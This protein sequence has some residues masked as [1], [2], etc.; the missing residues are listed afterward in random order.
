MS[1]Y[2]KGKRFMYEHVTHHKTI[3]IAKGSDIII[4]ESINVPRRSMRGLVLLFYGPYTAGT[5]NS[6]KSLNPN[7]DE[8]K[9]VVNGIPN[10]LFS[11]GIKTRDLWEE[12][13]GRFGKEK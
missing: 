4:N 6:E 5:R 11:Q 2:L 13:F 8:V 7:I 10:M 12:I 9:V 1:N 3:S